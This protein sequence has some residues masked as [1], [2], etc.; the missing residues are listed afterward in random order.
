MEVWESSAETGF[1]TEYVELS[2]NWLQKS[3]FQL[4]LH[5]LCASQ[6]RTRVM[7]SQGLLLMYSQV[8]MICVCG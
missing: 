4:S 1:D 6:I 3:F 2:H 8:N 5:H 7:T